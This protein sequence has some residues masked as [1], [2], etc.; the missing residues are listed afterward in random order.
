MCT[1]KE[2]QKCPPQVCYRNETESSPPDK[3]MLAK[4]SKNIQSSTPS[5]AW[6]LN[7]NA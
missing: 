3:P 1:G 4:I 5:P 7:E 6:S 2:S